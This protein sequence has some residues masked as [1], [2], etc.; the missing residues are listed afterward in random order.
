ML[1]LPPVLLALLLE[2]ETEL[3]RWWQLPPARL[4]LL[5]H[6]DFV[7]IGLSGTTHDKAALLQPVLA[8]HV[9]H[10]AGFN[11]ELLTPD[12]ALL[13]Y[14]SWQLAADGSLQRQALRS[15]IWLQGPAGWQL[16]FHQGTA[17]VNLE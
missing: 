12:S 10:T 16:R 15:S 3:H 4:A 7:E 14:H 13:R 1:P 5:L 17:I 2:Q 11:A 8:H 6:D 9:V